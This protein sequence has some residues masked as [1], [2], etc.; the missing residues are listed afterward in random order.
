VPILLAE[1]PF[2]Y[3]D[4]ENAAGLRSS[5]RRL[6]HTL[7]PRAPRDLEI[8]ILTT[9]HPTPIQL[10]RARGRLSIFTS[11]ALGLGLALG[12]TVAATADCAADLDGNGIIDGADLGALLAVWGT[13]DAAADLNGD[14]IVDGADLGVLLSAWGTTCE[15]G[16]FVATELAGT[17]INGS[18]NFRFD[19][20]F[21][22]GGSVWVAIDPQRHPE[23]VGKA[24]LIHVVAN[25][26]ADA[27]RSDPTLIDVRP[28]GAQ[29]VVFG[30]TIESCTFQIDAGALPGGTGVDL[31]AL[32]DVV[33]DF[34]LDGV[35]SAGDFID[36]YGGPGFAVVRNMTLSGPYPVTNLTYTVTGVTSGFGGQRAFFPTSIADLG[37]RPL[38]IVS[39]GNGH[40]YLWYNWLGTHLASYGYIVITHQNNTQPGIQAASTTTLQHTQAAIA[41]QAT[42]ADGALNGLIDSSQIVWIGHSRGGEGVVRAYT[43]ILSGN[44]VP[45]NY[46][47]DDIRLIASIAPTDFLG[48]VSSNP[49]SVPYHL[50]Y[51]A[52]DGDVCGCP[53][54]A[55]AFSFSLFERAES[56]RQS[57]YIHGT[58][59]NDFHCCGVNDFTGPAGTALGKAETQR[60]ARAAFLPLIKHILEDDAVALE[61]LWRPYS[62]LRPAGVATN[63][64][65][66]RDHRPAPTAD[67]FVIDDFQTNTSAGTSSS[68]GAVS[69]TVDNLVEAPLRDLNTSFTWLS[70]DPMNGMT[71]G[72]ATDTARGIV[73]EYSGAPRQ[74]DFEVVGDARDMTAWTWLAFRAAQGTR[75]PFTDESNVFHDFRVTLVDGQGGTGSISIVPQG[76][77]IRRPY[78]RTGFGTGAGWQNEFA[79][80][81]LRLTDFVAPPLGGGNALDLADIVTVRFEFGG[82]G[83]E[84]SGRIALDDL[85]LL[86]N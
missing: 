54:N 51:G 70:T 12:T 58:S 42:I 19:L 7:S 68:G 61:Y 56:F 34:D 64:T 4:P 23:I 47:A 52:A 37:P 2:I 31:A 26:S 28:A 53:N 75:H 39:H 65:A 72:R 59:H 33:V 83:L 5:D 45:T 10:R 11:I 1:L 9:S 73:F 71:R 66:V 30:D 50:I 27:W 46:T 8:T 49:N 82:P 35:L 63:V 76:A 36:G 79:T 69:F 85:R 80:V 62:A 60:I 29:A 3:Q 14:G 78:A 18:P 25:R 41:Q 43:R 74:I 44:F 6:S 48:S 17:P 81:R 77:G 21:N 67:A 57:L 32:Y 13:P 38:V 22:V 20:A 86:S 24:A 15:T 55:V 16:T 84:T 40:S